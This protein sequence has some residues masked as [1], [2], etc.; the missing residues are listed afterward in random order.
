MKWVLKVKKLKLEG[1]L[2]KKEDVMRNELSP[3]CSKRPTEFLIDKSLAF[4]CLNYSFMKMWAMYIEQAKNAK[5]CTK[6]PLFVISRN[7]L[8]QLVQ[9]GKTFFLLFHSRCPVVS[10]IYRS[11]HTY[12]KNNNTCNFKVK[13]H[14]MILNRKIPFKNHKT[15]FKEIF[16]HLRNEG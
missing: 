6:D 9:K 1:Y 7:Q 5:W 3:S 8:L 16:L 12:M 2:K 15:L 11:S 13:C 4:F 10:Q 14:T